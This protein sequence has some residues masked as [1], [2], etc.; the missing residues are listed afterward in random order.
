MEDIYH[1][2]G[3][4]REKLENWNRTEFGS[5][6]KQLKTMRAQLNNLRERSLRSGPTKEEKDLM[7]RISEL[8]AREEANREAT[9]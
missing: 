7:N 8:L 5:V 4:V 3:A 9:F 1:A 2:L 6:K